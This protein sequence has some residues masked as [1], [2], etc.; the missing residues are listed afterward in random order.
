MRERYEI[1]RQRDPQTREAL[2]KEQS[3]NLS[4]EVKGGRERQRRLEE[5]VL[6]VGLML[7]RLCRYNVSDLWRRL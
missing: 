4:L 5:R 1:S 6:P 2:R 3:E 7:M